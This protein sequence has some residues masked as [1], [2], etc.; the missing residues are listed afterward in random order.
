MEDIFEKVF[1]VFGYNLPNRS[2]FSATV[3]NKTTTLTINKNFRTYAKFQFEYAKFIGRKRA[4]A[5]KVETKRKVG[6]SNEDKGV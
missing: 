1:E 4:S 6:T 3:A 2:N 5:V